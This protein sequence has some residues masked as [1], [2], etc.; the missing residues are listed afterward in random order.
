MHETH[1]LCL[2][3]QHGVGSSCVVLYVGGAYDDWDATSHQR[4]C[5]LFCHIVLLLRDSKHIRTMSCCHILQASHTLPFNG[6][7]TSACA[8]VILHGVRHTRMW[9]T[10]T[11]CPVSW[12]F[13]C[14]TQEQIRRQYPLL[15]AALGH[16]RAPAF[17]TG[18]V[19]SMFDSCL[20]SVAASRH[21]GTIMNA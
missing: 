6:E 18:I 14:M 11:S 7:D 12:S 1:L 21:R 13:L 2:Q 10:P 20:S 5:I 16:N 15:E 4:L 8:Y 9:F 19:K 17:Y 3:H